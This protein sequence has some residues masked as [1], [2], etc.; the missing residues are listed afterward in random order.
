MSGN[1]P[2]WPAPD[3]VTVQWTVAV[4]GNASE[5]WLAEDVRYVW[6]QSGDDD[7]GSV[8]GL[9]GVP[10]PLHVT[11]LPSPID[12]DTEVGAANAVTDTPGTEA[13]AE[14]DPHPLKSHIHV[15][16]FTN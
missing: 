7:F 4:T 15:G 12:H 16:R 10:A 6:P 11:V 9:N 8:P 14:T 2:P 3:H 13:V 5:A 1:V